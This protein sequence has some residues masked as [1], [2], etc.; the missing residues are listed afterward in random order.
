V[1]TKLKNFIMREEKQS[2]YDKLETRNSSW[3]ALT[4][5]ASV[6]ILSMAFLIAGCSKSSVYD[7][8]LGDPLKADI[9]LVVPTNLADSVFVDPVV[10]VTFKPGIDPDIISATSISLKKGTA[11]V[12]GTIAFTG[13]TASFTTATDLS[14]ETEYTATVTSPPISGSGSNATHEYSWRFKTGKK[15]RISTLAV[16]SVTPA[17][18]AAEVQ[19][20]SSLLVTFNQELSTSMKSSVTIGLKKGT[21]VVN[22]AVVFSGSTATFQPSAALDAKTLYAGKVLIAGYASEKDDADKSGN[23]FNWSFTT[24]GSAADVTAPVVNTVV[25]ANNA[26]AIVTSTKAT[27][28]FSEA[29]NPATITAATFSLKQGSTAVP[30]AVSYTGTTAT[31]TP[32]A[33]LTA[34]LVYTAT[35]TSGVKDV[36]G[37]ALAAPYVWSFTTGGGVDVTAPTV[38]SVVPVNAATTAPTTT[39]VTVTFS[40]AMNATTISSASFTLKQGSTAV[41]GTV[42]YSGTTATF[43]PTAAL[44]ANTLY[45]ATVT[46]AVKDIAGNAL[47]ANYTWS[48][49]TAAVADV[50]APTVVSVIPAMN[51]TSVALST[52]A[53]ATFSEA[54]DAAT[55]TSSTFTL[56]QGTTA[57][58]GTV[59]YSGT[60]ATFTPSAALTGSTVYTATITTGS[61]DLAGNAV[62]SAYSWSFTTVAPVPTGKSFSA[63]VVPILTICNTCHTHPWTPS[64]NA[65]T[66]YTNLVSQ[67]YVSPTSPTTSKIYTKLTGGHPGSTVTTAQVNTILTWFTEGAKN[68]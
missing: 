22:G 19:V 10:S 62:A 32:S 15:H 39:K 49:T 4:I 59:T 44:A 21:T 13:T 26:T 47:A 57:V 63:D 65:S 6:F 9:A 18:K 3:H 20:A 64:T 30:G 7:P 55:I 40:E 42:S 37:N 38:L 58:A 41:A 5:F 25:P 60:K 36:A 45:N 51:A 50:T 31:F 17:D 61:K 27:V 34:G 66:F 8:A 68:N 16:V 29:M 33:A 54:M 48:F 11:A 24:A 46:M 2:N 43:S 12:P 53:S 67:G 14:P 52:V 35:V 23:A 1:S 56:K 28:T